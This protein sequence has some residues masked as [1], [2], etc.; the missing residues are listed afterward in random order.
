MLTNKQFRQNV[1][2]SGMYGKHESVN[3]EEVEREDRKHV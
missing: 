3:E 2:V 1:W